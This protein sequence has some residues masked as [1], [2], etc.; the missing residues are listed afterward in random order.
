M[1]AQIQAHSKGLD[2]RYLTISYIVMNTHIKYNMVHSGSVDIHK[3]LYQ[4]AIGS[5][6]FLLS[7]I[8]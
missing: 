3:F 7:V 2:T 6:F 1:Q 8:F 5:R 4:E